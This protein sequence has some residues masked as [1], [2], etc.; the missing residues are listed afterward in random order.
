MSD[1][2]PADK[3]DRTGTQSGLPV[4]ADFGFVID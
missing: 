1:L 2:A 3:P 4:S